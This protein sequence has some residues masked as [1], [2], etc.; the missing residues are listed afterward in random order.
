MPLPNNGPV[1]GAKAIG[2]FGRL[3]LK[4][5]DQR[6]FLVP[7]NLFKNLMFSNFCV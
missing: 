7:F 2:V 4:G 6:S 5:Q 3:I 1:M